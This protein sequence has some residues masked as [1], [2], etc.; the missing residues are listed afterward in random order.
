MVTAFQQIAFIFKSVDDNKLS[1]EL[2]KLRD[3]GKLEQAKALLLQSIAEDDML[4]VTE[5]LG[6]YCSLPLEV[7]EMLISDEEYLTILQKLDERASNYTDRTIYLSFMVDTLRESTVS[8]RQQALLLATRYFEQL[9]GNPSCSDLLDLLPLNSEL[10]YNAMMTLTAFYDLALLGSDDNL[11]QLVYQSSRVL[12]ELLA[13]CVYRIIGFKCASMLPLAAALFTVFSAGETSNREHMAYS[14]LCWLVKLLTTAE[15]SVAVAILASVLKIVKEEGYTCVGATTSPK[16]SGF[17]LLCHTL[18]GAGS[19]I[20]SGVTLLCKNLG[21]TE[22]EEHRVEI[23]CLFYGVCAESDLRVA[24]LLGQSVVLLEWMNSK[25]GSVE[26]TDQAAVME[27][28]EKLLTLNAVDENYMDSF[29]S[30]S[31]GLRCSGKE[32][33]IATETL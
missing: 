16:R 27:L 26:P 3:E 12:A 20:T 15:Q 2:E 14:L 5:L 17:V 33:P 10:A 4:A 22:Y 29:R 13:S 18:L 8:V 30:L 25:I 24:K 21:T 1:E 23:L 28:A 7:K 31:R 6:L 9:V 11:V 19:N 32:A